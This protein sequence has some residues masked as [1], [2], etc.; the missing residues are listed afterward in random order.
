MRPK[1]VVATANETTKP[2]VGKGV[3]QIEG[4]TDVRPGGHVNGH[5]NIYEGVIYGIF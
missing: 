5:I 3:I 4:R 2:P 1:T